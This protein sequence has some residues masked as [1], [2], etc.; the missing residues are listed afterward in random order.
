MDT[1]HTIHQ[2][3]EALRRLW[4]NYQMVVSA[5]PASRKW[6]VTLIISRD[7]APN[8]LAPH[9]MVPGRVLGVEVAVHADIRLPKVRVIVVYGSNV[10]AERK[11]VQHSLEKTLKQPTLLWGIGTRPPSS[12]TPHAYR[13]MSGLG[14][15]EC[16]KQGA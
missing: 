13:P 3:R 2:Y 4:G 16:N 1:N 9:Q 5:N 8:D 14:Y 12:L 10:P 7:V 15:H 11:P 6:G